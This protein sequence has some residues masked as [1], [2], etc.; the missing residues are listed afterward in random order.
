MTWNQIENK[1]AA[2]ARRVRADWKGAMQDEVAQPTAERRNALSD[3][4]PG[5]VLVS[6]ACLPKAIAALAE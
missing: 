4:E 5:T 6:D 2:M 1:W 3:K